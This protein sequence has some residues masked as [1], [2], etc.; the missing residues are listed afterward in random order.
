MNPLTVFFASAFISSLI[1]RFLADYVKIRLYIQKRKKK[2]RPK[3][4]IIHDV[5]GKSIRIRGIHI[6]HFVWGILALIVAF[7][8]AYKD[9]QP[10]DMAVVGLAVA[11]I[12]SEFK[13]IILQGW[14]K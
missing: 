9:V 3:I 11:L 13:E 12:M 5:L 8:L 2:Y 6:H 7:A 4:L 1:I 14:G 10:Y